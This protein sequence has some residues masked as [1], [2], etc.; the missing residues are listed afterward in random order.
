MKNSPKLSSSRKKSLKIPT[1][2][3]SRN[4]KTTRTTKGYRKKWKKSR[5]RPLVKSCSHTSTRINWTYFQRPLSRRHFWPK[6]RTIVSCQCTASSSHWI[7]YS[8][9]FSTTSLAMEISQSHSRTFL[10]FVRA[11]IKPTKATSWRWFKAVFESNKLTFTF[12]Y[13]NCLPEWA[14]I[15]IGSWS[16]TGWHI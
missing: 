8:N 7:W 10:P 5:S 15:I 12:S 9:R 13:A 4:L 3:S 6:W 1:K 2:K 16:Y 14:S 11:S